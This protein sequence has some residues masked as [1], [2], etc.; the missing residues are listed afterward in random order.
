VWRAEEA[1][2][3]L[4]LP[5]A[6]STPAAAAACVRELHRAAAAGSAHG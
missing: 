5:R 2:T 4:P 3:P 6:T 1:S